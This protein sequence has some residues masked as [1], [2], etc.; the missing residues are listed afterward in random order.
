[1]GLLHRSSQAPGSSWQGAVYLSSTPSVTSSSVLLGTVT[2]NDTL[3]GG[4]SYNRLYPD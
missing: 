3:T 2:E 4:G 1:M